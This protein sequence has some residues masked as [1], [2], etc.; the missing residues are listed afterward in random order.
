[1]YE[2][3]EN[4]KRAYLVLKE[5]VLLKTYMSPE[6]KKKKIPH[7]L[8]FITELV[9][10]YPQFSTATVE[11]FVW[12]EACPAICWENKWLH[13]LFMTEESREAGIASHFEFRAKTPARPFSE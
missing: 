12:Y 6:A 10:D 8:K 3:K 7:L 11:N 13:F 2:L 4:T 5:Q 9:K 1:M